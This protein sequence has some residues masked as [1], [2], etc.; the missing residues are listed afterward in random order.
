VRVYYDDKY[1]IQFGVY[2]WWNDS[3]EVRTNK[4]VDVCSG[5]PSTLL[6]V[7]VKEHLNQRITEK[8]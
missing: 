5:R 8:V 1:K 6:C 7:E 4:V 3:K 2:K